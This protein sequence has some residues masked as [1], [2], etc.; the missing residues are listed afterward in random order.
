MHKLLSLI[1]IC[2]TLGA[3]HQNNETDTALSNA[4]TLIFSAPDSAV[5]LLDSLSTGDMSDF[6]RA[7]HSLLLA[8]ARA[9]AGIILAD[10]PADSLLSR[11]IASLSKATALFQNRGDSLETQTLFYLGVLLGYRGDYSDALIALMESADISKNNNDHF[12]LAMSYREQAEIY[13]DLYAFEQ[14][15]KFGKLAYESFVQANRPLHAKWEQVSLIPSLSYSNQYEE[16]KELI[17][18]LLNDSLILSDETL[19]RQVYVHAC[20]LSIK[21]SDVEKAEKYFNAFLKEGGTPSSRLYAAMTRISLKAGDIDNAK[22]FYRKA[23]SK[24]EDDTDSLA[25]KLALAQLQAAES[26]FQH[27]YLNQTKVYNRLNTKVNRLTTHPYTSLLSEHYHTKSIEQTAQRQIAEQR[28]WIGVLAIIMLIAFSC[29]L[30]LYYR[31]RLLRKE[32]E[33]EHI[34]SDMQAL[35]LKLE[36]LIIQRT[37]DIENPRLSALPATLLNTLCKSRYI[38]SPG[39]KGYKDIGKIAVDFIDTI[40]SSEILSD[41]ELY[42]DQTNNGLMT[43]FREQITN[44]P[45]SYYN[46]AL[47]TFIGFSNDSI[48]CILKIG[49]GAARNAR[50]KIRA[51]INCADCPDKELFL[52]YFKK[53]RG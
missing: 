47:L 37:P 29:L 26:D 1:I 43:R 42:I 40:K 34:F 50:S 39:D 16:A 52:I 10:S 28:I 33:L 17:T 7:R 24:A 41:L 23:I 11:S 45:S 6:Q 9:K 25:A 5:T 53:M 48:C 31:K 44:L 12:Y 22:Q 21:L 2:L 13:T 36:S 19:R 8:K 51:A 15:A 49:D 32:L 14:A 46:L 30:S 27:A 3:C 4:D 35:Q 20:E 38:L 18:T